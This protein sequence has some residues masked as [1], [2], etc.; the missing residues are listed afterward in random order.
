M[1]H[2]RPTSANAAPTT[3][4][5]PTCSAS[6]SVRCPRSSRPEPAHATRRPPHAI[7]AGVFA[8]EILDTYP[9]DSAVRKRSG[10]VRNHDTCS[11]DHRHRARSAE[12]PL[13]CVDLARLRQPYPSRDEL[14]HFPRSVAKS[15]D[16]PARAGSTTPRAGNHGSTDDQVP[17]PVRPAGRSELPRIRGPGGGA[18]ARIRHDRGNHNEHGTTPRHY[19]ALP[20]ANISAG[21]R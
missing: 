18:T 4:Y 16:G 13:G 5:G 3:L 14:P 11:C 12:S 9:K 17:K 7:R 20:V 19:P 6:A 8:W 15:D 10:T 2:C 21:N 1:A